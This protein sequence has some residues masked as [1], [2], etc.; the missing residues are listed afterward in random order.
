MI[1][2][3]N[4]GLKW[5]LFL[6]LS[7]IWGSSFILMK[8]GMEGLN[9][10]QVAS[11]RIVASGLVLLPLTLKSFR[12]IPFNKIP[13]VALSGALGSL[14]PAYLFCVAESGIDSSLAG[15]L[16]SLTPI[17]TI[18]TGAL[19]FK[20]HTSTQ[21]VIGVMIAFFGC[22]GLFLSQAMF[23]NENHYGFIVFV[24]MATVC[25][26]VNVNVVQRY[27][28]GIPSLM[29]V[30]MAMSICAVPALGMLIFTGYFSAE[31]FSTAMITATLYSILLG[32]VGTSV[33]NILFYV[34]IKNAGPIFASM[35][36]YGIPFVAIGWGL[37]YGEN[38]GWGQIF[39]LFVIL[40]GVYVANRKPSGG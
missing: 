36:T 29:I 38:I 15:A 33:A 3:G 22:A 19:F 23:S 10:Y 37:T 1:D 27:L 8:K 17:F 7:L 14:F 40:G 28:K 16:N 2:M 34:L 11:I 18:L 4:K 12:S 13:V 25:Y 20:M 32:A 35:V 30:S 9:A 5:L 26:G 31:P 21:K 6:L 24:M 39:S